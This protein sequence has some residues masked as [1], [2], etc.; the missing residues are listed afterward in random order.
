MNN[1][2]RFVGLSSD[3]ATKIGRVLDMFAQLLD[4]FLL[5]L[6]IGVS[7]LGSIYGIWLGVQ[8]ART[9]GD[10]RGEAKKRLINFFIGIVALLVLLL[11][12]RI[13]TTNAESVISWIESA[14]IDDG[15]FGGAA[16]WGEGIT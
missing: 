6:I 15:G 13:F 3:K 5:P 8:Y 10:A 7:I 2:I 16:G 12:L 4:E 14:I 11:V 9:E 1:I